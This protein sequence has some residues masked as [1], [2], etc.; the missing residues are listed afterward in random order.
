MNKIKSFLLVVFL[1]VPAVG[2]S[3]SQP[4]VTVIQAAA[5]QG[6]A[7]AQAQVGAVY[8]LGKGVLQD[9]SV[10]ARW[11]KK[12]ADQGVVEAVVMMG[13]LSDV[14]LGVPPSARDAKAWYQKAVALGSEPAKGVLSYYTDVERAMK[15]MGI[16]KQYANL[17]LRKK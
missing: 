17:I 9:R 13:A 5:D 12:A 2:W 3:A 16:A 4:D 14:G 7:L 1:L 15:A 10:A 11:L 8:Y 6:D